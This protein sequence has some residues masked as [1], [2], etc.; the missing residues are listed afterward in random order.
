VNQNPQVPA[1]A[2][3]FAIQVSEDEDFENIV[4]SATGIAASPHVMPL[5]DRLKFNR[6]YNWRV[7]FSGTL[8]G[9]WS[10]SLGFLTLTPKISL[11]LPEDESTFV[12]TAPTLQ[13]MPPSTGF[14]Y[15]VELSETNTF[16]EVRYLVSTSPS[17]TISDG[18]DFGTTYY[19]RVRGE[20]ED[21]VITIPSDIWS[22]TTEPVPLIAPRD[23]AIDVPLRPTLSFVANPN[24][25]STD[26]VVSTNMNLSQPERM[27]VSVPQG[28]SQLVWPT[29][30]DYETVYYWAIIPIIDDTPIPSSL[31]WSFTTLD[32]P[33]PQPDVPDAVTKISPTDGSEDVIRD[34]VFKWQPV[35]DIT[36]LWIRISQSEDMVQGLF[37]NS[38]N[39]NTTSF[40]RQDLLLP[41]TTY[42]WTVVAENEEGLGPDGDIWSF[43]TGQDTSN[44]SLPPAVELKS[45]L[46]DTTDMEAPITVE[47][48]P[49]P[50][51]DGYTIRLSNTPDFSGNNI[52]LVRNASDSSYTFAFSLLTGTKYYWYVLAENSAGVSPIGE[53]WSFTTKAVTIIVPQLVTLVSP[54]A[55]ETDVS[56]TAQFK[57][58]SSIN[59]STYQIQ[60][61]R[62]E[63]FATLDFTADNIADTT[64]L[65]LS[66]LMANTTYY[67]RVRGKSVTT[68]GAWSAIRSFTVANMQTSI[69]S[70]AE[71]P[72][73][74]KIE[75]VY[76][77]PFNPVTTIQYAI[78]NSGSVSLSVLDVTGREVMRTSS[79]NM[80]AG[81]HTTLFDGRNLSSGLYIVS[82]RFEG[83]TKS[84]KITLLK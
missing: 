73:E 43:T 47:W 17:I 59:S 48:K 41:E 29:D 46:N 40:K 38:L 58:N 67:W 57:W 26:V 72:N 31:I 68:I 36:E 71:L 78:P 19:W 64:Y 51:V 39:P 62:D 45:P 6:A 53:I 1:G 22:F 15:V 69:D 16:D 56:K 77:N 50:D 12:R 65:A 7:R 44:P 42:Y 75:R 30:L 70:D 52:S 23:E 32:E 49:V 60:I 74:F 82:L 33:P 10:Q 35:N 4:Y 83:Q 63:Q 76:P 34:V 55:G 2:G 20:N 54:V 21:G 25:T 8:D 28:Q 80:A 13:W 3:T 79:T 18:L 66:E 81:M 9:N 24:A 27:V 37:V 11:S 14:T 5:T 61:S 84:M